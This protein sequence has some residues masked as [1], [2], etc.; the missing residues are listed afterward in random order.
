[1]E[2]SICM[3]HSLQCCV[4][5]KKHK[6]PTTGEK[7]NDCLPDGLLCSYLRW[8]LCDYVER[9][10]NIYN[11]LR[12]AGYKIASADDDHSYVLKNELKI[13]RQHD[14]C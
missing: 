10:V 4:Y 8:W 1:M 5:K 7:L 12:K 2:K 11:V 14:I 13:A 3:R 9:W 6:Y